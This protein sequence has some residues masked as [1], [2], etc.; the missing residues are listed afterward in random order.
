MKISDSLNFMINFDD[1]LCESE[2]S[3]IVN[4]ESVCSE[5][6]QQF[7]NQKIDFETF[8]DTVESQGLDIDDYL[9]NSGYNLGLWTPD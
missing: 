5:A 8:V 9:E 1:G 7:L 6:L 2:I 3:D 4:R